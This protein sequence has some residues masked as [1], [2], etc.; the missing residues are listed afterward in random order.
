MRAPWNRKKFCKDLELPTKKIYPEWWD[1]WKIIKDNFPIGH[2]FKMLGVTILVAKHSDPGLVCIYT[3]KQNVI[4]QLLFSYSDFDLL[5]IL[6]K[7][8]N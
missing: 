2:T 7:Q 1:Q 5:L 6:I 4:H 8:N 3:D